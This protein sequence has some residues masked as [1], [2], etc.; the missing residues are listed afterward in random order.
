MSLVFVGCYSRKVRVGFCPVESGCPE[1]VVNETRNPLCFRH[2]R[3][4]NSATGHFKK[5]GIQLR[6]TQ[7]RCH[8]SW[9][10][11]SCVGPL[12]Y[13]LGV[14]P[15]DYNKPYLPCTCQEIGEGFAGK[16]CSLLVGP[17]LWGEGLMEVF[18]ARLLGR[19]LLCTISLVRRYIL[20]GRLANQPDP[21]ACLVMRPTVQH[22]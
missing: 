16:L 1:E 19:I 18:L 7:A 2:V 13:K 14:P 9:V 8:V 6:R 21:Q 22:Q 10:W 12:A 3:N 4:V 11:I 15:V 20:V 5:R 17:R